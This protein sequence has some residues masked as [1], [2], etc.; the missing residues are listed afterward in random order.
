MSVFINS[1][2]TFES[3]ITGEAKEYRINNAVWAFLKSKFDLS[4]TEWAM[5]FEQEE[6]L[7]G[8]KFVVCVL[9]ANGLE[10][11]EQ[12]VLENTNAMDVANFVI[13]YQ[14]AMLKKDNSHVKKEEETEGK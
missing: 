13:S 6:V 5:G 1:L 9:Q 12:E 2:K 3:D 11:T 14:T 8:A 4:Q 10:V 7:Y